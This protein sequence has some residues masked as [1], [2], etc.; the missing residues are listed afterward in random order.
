MA[1]SNRSSMMDAKN[2]LIFALNKI[3]HNDIRK[4]S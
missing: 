2:I 3:G 1:K 4:F